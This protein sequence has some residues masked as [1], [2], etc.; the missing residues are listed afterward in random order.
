MQIN[1]YLFFNGDCEDAFKFYQRVLGGEIVAMITHASTPA[2]EHVAP[3]LQNKIIHARLVVDG[4]VL[5]GS[6]SPPEY[7]KPMAGCSVSVNVDEPAEAERIFKELSENGSVQMPMEETFWAI[8]FG[9]LTDRFGI[10]WMIN[11]ERPQP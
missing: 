9:M 2:A 7:F 11:S 1:P 8:R 3:E 4:R 6:D 10:P 5:M